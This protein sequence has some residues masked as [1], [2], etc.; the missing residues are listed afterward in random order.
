MRFLLGFAFDTYINLR[1]CIAEAI[2]QIAYQIE[3]A[4]DVW[5]EDE[6]E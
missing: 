6:D 1:Y 5:G 2:K 3:D 4:L